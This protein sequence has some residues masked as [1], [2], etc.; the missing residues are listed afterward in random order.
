MKSVV[1]LGNWE[2]A[3]KGG[4]SVVAKQIAAWNKDVASKMHDPAWDD[5]VRPKNDKVELKCN[6]PEQGI[7]MDWEKQKQ[8]F[9]D[10]MPANT[11]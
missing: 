8:Q 11:E 4:S 1:A 5:I 2:I 6:Q 3:A 10:S 9:R 7:P